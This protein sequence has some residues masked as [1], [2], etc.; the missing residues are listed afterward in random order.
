[1]DRFGWDAFKAFYGDMQENTK[2]QAAML[3]AALQARFDLTLSQAE[4]AWL[5]EL[6]VL[7][8]PTAQIGD[9]RL[10]TDFYDTLRRYQ[11]AWDPSAYFLQAWLPS[12]SEAE[13]LGITADWLRHPSRPLNVAL[14]TMLIA[15]D[16]AIDEGAYAWGEV[17][18]AAVNAALDAGG[19]TE[20][21]PL[22]ADYAALVQAT[23][24]AG[25]QAQQIDLDLESDMARVL[26]VV[27][28]G[29]DMVELSFVRRAGAWRLIVSSGD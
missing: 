4:S 7:P 28:E 1:M 8:T 17:L 27:A 15:A 3:D 19:D 20:I 12:L 26:A 25:Y 10:T 18:L 24:E 21:D 22:A 14:E 29:M 2:G 9:L 23:V 16:R 13:R 11:Q 6:R 5:A